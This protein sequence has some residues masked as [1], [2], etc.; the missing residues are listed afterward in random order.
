MADD[1]T[2]RQAILTRGHW[3][4]EIKPAEYVEERVDDLGA[5]AAVVPQHNVAL[6][7]WDYPHIDTKSPIARGLDWAGQDTE[8]HEHL[9]SWRIFAS[10]LFV[11]MN[12]LRDDWRDR[13]SFSPPKEGWVPGAALDV[14]DAIFTLT[15]VF[16]FASRLATS[17]VGAPT[18]AVSSTLVGA[19]GR[20]LYVDDPM[21][22][23]LYRDYQA[24]VDAIPL[25]TTVERTRLLAE[26]WDIAGIQSRKLFQVFGF[27]CPLTTIHD[28]Q[29]EMSEWSRSVPRRKPSS[30]EGEPA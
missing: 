21:R 2:I 6:R 30:T 7:G 26:S 15:E 4:I 3:R 14:G 9:D 29:R 11:S 8:W 27:D 28:F 25:E 5:L 10:G 20:T 19:K 18:V 13:S 1:G 24:A 22:G 17:P 16:E 12:G 23:S